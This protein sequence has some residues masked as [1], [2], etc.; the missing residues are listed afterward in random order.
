MNRL[1]ILGVS[2]LCLGGIGMSM[3]GRPLPPKPSLPE[4]PHAM[5]IPASFI[6]NHGQWPEDVRFAA[7]CGSTGLQVHADGLTMLRGSE[8][9]RM[10]F[11]GTGS[12]AA[13]GEGEPVGR[14]HILLGND[15]ALWHRDM[16]GYRSVRLRGVYPGIDVRI[17]ADGGRFEY[18]LLLQPKADLSRVVLAWEGCQGMKTGPDGNLRIATSSGELVQRI[19]AVWEVKADGGKQAVACRFRALGDCRHGFDAPERN[20]ALAMVLDPTLEW[21]SYLGGAGAEEIRDITRDP[22]TGDLVVVGYT[23][24]STGF[25]VSPTTIFGAGTVLVNS[26]FNLLIARIS[27]DGATLLSTLVV[28]G[29][30]LD[31]GRAV[32]ISN[33]W[34][35]VAGITESPNFPVQG[36]QGAPPIDAAL[37]G[38]RDGFLLA[39]DGTG[40]LQVST[41]VGG[42]GEDETEDLALTPNGPFVCGRTYSPDLAPT[43]NALMATPRDGFIAGFSPN[44]A[45]LSYLSYIGGPQTLV[46][47]IH[48]ASTIAYES[49]SGDLLI[50][51]C[52]NLS[53]WSANPIPITPG[54]LYSA[55]L[56]STDIY[57]VRLNPSTGALRASTLWGSSSIDQLEAMTVTPDGTIWIGGLCSSTYPQTSGVPPF[58][59]NGGFP[60]FVT[61][62][63]VDP[64]VSSLVYSEIFGSPLGFTYV[65]DL[66]VLHG[67][68]FACGY[69]NGTQP[70]GT[71]LGA[72]NAVGTTTHGFALQLRPGT[73]G[74]AARI[75]QA[76][77][78][79]TQFGYLYAVLPRAEGGAMLAGSVTGPNPALITPGVM[80]PNP[81]MNLFA[82]EGYVAHA[83]MLP[84]GLSRFGTAT[85]SCRGASV[86][87]ADAQ[88]RQGQPFTLTCR[89]APPGSLTFVVATVLPNPAGPQVLG[90]RYF[91]DESQGSLFFP[92]YTDVDGNLSI[93]GNLP[94][95]LTGL[96]YYVQ[97]IH[98]DFLCGGFTP[99]TASNAL[100]IEVQP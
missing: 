64:M 47:S 42:S 66:D 22:L 87:G 34:T 19:P 28:G 7:T 13:E 86:I 61:A 54:A 92:V 39:V 93:T 68:V 88:P 37:G 81:S 41:Y 11:E 36:F 29:S 74:P 49:I 97:C 63:R 20:E 45:G 85:P 57:L 18:D 24:S 65:T 100:K 43:P 70:L 82:S 4:A 76:N 30:G 94:T 71:S 90:F 60:A 38:G 77:L 16:P 32:K 59:N 67:D 78:G 51:G 58:V 21:G 10:R 53:D 84:V 40:N 8:R 31:M 9:L 95:G 35:W 17:R 2:T 12:A 27:P 91:L 33:G 44:A 73:S 1:G 99:F 75:H 26:N 50:G 79:G 56:G 5:S 83:A 96:T 55:P 62:L 14:H 25:P 52:S 6:A 46:T 98:Y 89:N 72:L 48:R 80:D 15:P 69:V 3:T 23:N